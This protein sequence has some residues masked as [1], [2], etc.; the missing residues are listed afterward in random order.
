MLLILGLFLHFITTINTTIFYIFSY[1]GII[2]LLYLSYKVIFSNS[3]LQES[4][5]H[6]PITFIQALLFQWVNPK[7]WVMILSVLTTFTTATESFYQQLFVII[8]LFIFFG[9]INC[10]TWAGLGGFIKVKL[11]SQKHLRYINTLLGLMLLFAIVQ[12][13]PDKL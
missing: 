9:I 12:M 11:S 8:T 4:D 3:K 13:I 10:F 2:Y 7:A 5:F 6:Q 1:L